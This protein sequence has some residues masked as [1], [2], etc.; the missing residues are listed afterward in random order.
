MSLPGWRD[1]PSKA[2]AAIGFASRR[3]GGLV[4]TYTL[5][6]VAVGLTTLVF[7]AIY[8]A[9]GNPVPPA[10]ISTLPQGSD[11]L[12]VVHADPVAVQAIVASLSV[13]G[14]VALNGPAS[15]G[16]PVA[17]EG[18]VLPGT[19]MLA[20]GDVVHVCSDLPAPSVDLRLTEA[21]TGAVLGIHT[22]VAP[23]LCALPL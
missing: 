20:G 16:T 4:A 17:M 2:R 13:P 8:A 18:V 3:T 15:S 19:G 7:A 23:P 11:G 21:T 1:D 22:F 10:N 6:V 14:R 9:G 5:V 12:Q